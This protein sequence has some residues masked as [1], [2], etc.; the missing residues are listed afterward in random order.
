M[1]VRAMDHGHGIVKPW[2]VTFTALDVASAQP[3][4]MLGSGV[5][6]DRFCVSLAVLPTV[7]SPFLEI[8]LGTL[9]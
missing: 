7:A 3:F 6:A 8:E 2:L 9:I 5:G 4:K 1:H